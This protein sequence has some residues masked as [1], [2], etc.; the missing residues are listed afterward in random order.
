MNTGLL[1]EHFWKHVTDTPHALALSE[2][3]ASGRQNW[4][5]RELSDLVTQYAYVFTQQ[6]AEG[7]Q[8]IGSCLVNSVHWIA[9]DLACQSLGLVH[10]AIDPRESNDRV[11]ELTRFA[12]CRLLL[13]APETSVALR[14]LG[15]EQV[16]PILPLKIPERSDSGTLAASAAQLNPS[17]AALMLFT[18]GTTGAHRGV[19]L[20]H[21]N[22]VTNASAKLMAAPQDSYDIRI[23]V[24]PFCHAYA[25]TCELST[26]LLTKG[27]LCLGG[28]WERVIDWAPRVQPTLINVVPFL[29]DKISTYLQ[30]N[31]HGL[32]DR[33]RLLQVGGAGLNSTTWQ[34]LA[35]LGLPPLIGYGLTE[36]SPVICSNFSHDQRSDTVGTA[37]QGVEIR[38]DEN[39]VLWTRGPHVMLGYWQDQN[40]TRRVICNGWLC[41]GDL[42]RITSSGHVQILGRLNSQI[43]LSTGYKV[44][45]EPLEFRILCDPAIQHVV[46]VGNNE[47]FLRA[48][49]WPTSIVDKKDTA[50][51]LESRYQRAA[52]TL[53]GFPSYMI[54]TRFELLP[55]PLSVANR[56]LTRK[57]TLRR[58]AIAQWL[59]STQDTL[60]L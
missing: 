45:P 21:D 22:L 18:S 34:E 60:S 11:I 52:E 56:T 35:E 4:T 49:V 2:L 47:P 53:Q 41:T 19:M 12:D 37:V 16:R 48:L 25:R 38:I 43:C 10:V 15:L 51:W 26:W 55:G 7:V 13:C 23:N 57:G 9:I 33:L 24:L 44:S 31:R 42:A 40:E 36:A 8:H 58:A 50:A 20:S 32:G 29:A 3:Q 17:A 39:Y 5:W 27:L 54:P 46:L 30:T 1:V 28:T 14:S 6:A 59:S